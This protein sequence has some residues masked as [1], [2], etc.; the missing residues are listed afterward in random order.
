MSEDAPLQMIRAEVSLS[1]FNR[2]MGVKRL[3]DPDHA[4]HCLLKE[5]F[6]DIAPQ[7]FRL[8]TPRG[9]PTGVFYG[10]TRS[11]ADELR[12]KAS[13]YADPSHLRALPPSSIDNK[14]MPSEWQT[15]K[16]LGFEVRIRP[17]VRIF[18]DPSNRSDDRQ[19]PSDV[20]SRFDRFKPPNRHYRMSPGSECDAFLWEAIRHLEKGGLQRTREE[21]YAQWLGDQL[22][23]RRGAEL[24]PGE[25]KL[26]SFQRTRAFRKPHSRYSEGPDAVMRG[27]LTITDP[28][29]FA[30][31]LAKGIGRH[32]AYGF[33][34]LLLRPPGRANGR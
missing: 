23:R 34:M 16:R 17:I 32:R 29:A 18:P 22:D 14:P 15:G 9:C 31:L 1:D 25:A 11:D 26:V 10:Y 2:W 13:T 5:S 21:V 28:V 30:Q 33:G 12:E 6:G 20:Q 7:P 24:E 19:I 27:N 4:M 8:I 3:Q